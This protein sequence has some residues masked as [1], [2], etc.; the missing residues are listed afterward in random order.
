MS[1]PV[2]TIRLQRALQYVPFTRHTVLWIVIGLGLYWGWREAVPNGGEEASSALAPFV[3]I[4]VKAAGYFL[5]GLVALS[6]GSAVIAW[7][8]YLV[9]RRRSPEARLAVDFSDQGRDGHGG[10]IWLRS[11]LRGA[12]R[13]LF[14]F[15]RG[16]L[17]YDDG[18]LTDSFTL[19]SAVRKKSGGLW[20]AGIGGTARMRLPDTREYRVRGGFLFFEDMLHLLSLPVH[21]GLAGQFYQ[22]PETTAVADREFAPKKTESLDVRIDEMRRV[23]GDYLQYKDFEAGDDVRRIVWPVYA[24]NRELVVRVPE[25]FEPYASHLYFYAS[26]AVAHGPVPN[27]R[28]SAALLNHFKTRV[29]SL[30]ETL[31]KTGF[32]LRYV[33]EQPLAEEAAG[34]TAVARSIAASRWQREV[35]LL[36]YFNPRHAAVLCIHS[37]TDPTEAAVALGALDRS[38][39]VY[40]VPLSAAIRGSAALHWLERILLRPSD[41]SAAKRLRGPWKVS[42][43]R[44]SLVRAE[45]AVEAALNQ[46]AATVVRI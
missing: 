17:L 29:W 16:R 32:Q 41:G 28:Y 2:R 46:T 38:T 39:V 8:H 30:H 11:A 12:L 6:V 36:Q 40:F 10:A 9:L 4:M 7:G 25:R 42:R 26:F 21:Q 15:V 20:R 35:P 18:V 27:S 23:E 5:L 33:A 13:P 14:G 19:L 44:L 45:R 24:R 3:R 1:L 34:D 43:A 37:L 22:L 31:A